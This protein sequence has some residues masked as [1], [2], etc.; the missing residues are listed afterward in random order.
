MKHCSVSV[1]AET[2]RVSWVALRS[3]GEYH[4]ELRIYAD[5]GESMLRHVRMPQVKEDQRRHLSDAEMW[6]VIEC[7]SEGEQ[8]TRDHAIVVTLL[9]TGV[10]REEVSVRLGDVDP[11]E[12][13]LR[14][15]A[16]TSQSVHARDIA[17]PME[18]LKALDRYVNDAPC[19]RHANAADSSDLPLDGAACRTPDEVALEEDDQQDDGHGVEHGA[20]EH[21]V[22]V[23]T[24]QSLK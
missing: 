5:N 1:S 9:G 21:P 4:A 15:R 23:H 6:K 3:L 11:H 2:A 19:A 17:L 22:P 24:K 13:L 18:V 10:R 8:G 20:G 14:V 12:R 16:T 7:S